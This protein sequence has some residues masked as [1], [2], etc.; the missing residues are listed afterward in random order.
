MDDKYGKGGYCH[1]DTD[2]ECDWE[3]CP[4][5]KEYKIGCPLFDWDDPDRRY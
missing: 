3:D 5:K 1:A 2:G 4:Q